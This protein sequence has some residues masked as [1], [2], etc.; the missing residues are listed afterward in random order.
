M[1]ALAISAANLNIIEDNLG[2]VAK[3]LNGVVSNVN[4][5]NDHVAE[6]E[7]KVESLKS[8]VSKVLPLSVKV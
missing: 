4:Y 5:M 8:V 6:V 2:A 7:T 3:E 1:E